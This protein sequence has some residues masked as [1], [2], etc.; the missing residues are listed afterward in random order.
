MWTKLK[1]SYKIAIFKRGVCAIF[2]TNYLKLL[3]HM[4]LAYHLL[5]LE[6]KKLVFCWTNSQ[7]EPQ[8]LF[9]KKQ[10]RRGTEKGEK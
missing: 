1:E 4:F 9:P 7:E 2:S 8:A 3:L 5:Y 6:L 10:R